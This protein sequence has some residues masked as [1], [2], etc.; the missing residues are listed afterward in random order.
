[1]KRGKL[2]IG[3]WASAV[4]A[5]SQECPARGDEVAGRGQVAS[6]VL[7]GAARLG[8]VLGARPVGEEADGNVVIAG[9]EKAW[10]GHELAERAPQGVMGSALDAEL[11]QHCRGGVEERVVGAADRV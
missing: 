10:S 7:A 1:M 9:I 6:G 4:V 5:L 11:Q 8:L 2:P 3:S